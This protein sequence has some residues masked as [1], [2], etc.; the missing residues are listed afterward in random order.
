MS[1]AQ[2]W[3]AIG[4]ISAIFCCSIVIGVYQ[5]SV[6]QLNSVTETDAS[7]FSMGNREGAEKLDPA[8][9]LIEI[10]FGSGEIRIDYSTGQEINWDCDGVGKKTVLEKDTSEKSVRLDFSSA[11]VDCD[12]TI[13]SRSLKIEGLHGEVELRKIDS[14]VEVHMING[15]LFLQPRKDREFKYD[16]NVESGSVDEAFVSSSSANTLLIKAEM[17]Y[18]NIES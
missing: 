14:N 11:I 2:R 8:V 9:K 13:P 15:E 10:K 4:F 1:L 6:H 7:E 3:F 5:W 16:L 17:K 12:I 18:G